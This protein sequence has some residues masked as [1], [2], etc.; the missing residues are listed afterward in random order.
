MHV[1][2]ERR[3]VI[4]TDNRI[5][6]D[7]TEI[8]NIGIIRIDREKLFEEFYRGEIKN[9][10]KDIGRHEYVLENGNVVP[11]IKIIDELLFKELTIKIIYIPDKK[12]HC[13]YKQI[14]TS[15]SVGAGNIL[16]DNRNNMSIK[17]YKE[18]VMNVL[19]WYL[20]ER[21]GI[22]ADFT[23]VKI[24]SMEIN[25][26]IPIQGKF[27][28]YSRIINL[29]IHNLPLRGNI[30]EDKKSRELAKTYSKRNNLEELVMYDKKQQVESK[31][32]TP[33][34]YE[35][36]KRKRELKKQ[37]LTNC[38]HKMKETNEKLEA[39]WEEHIRIE[40][41][42]YNKGKNKKIHS[43]QQKIEKFFGI[44]EATLD[45]ITDE[46]VERKFRQY[47]KEKILLPFCVWYCQRKKEIRKMVIEDKKNYGQS[48]QLY[49]YPKL[50]KIEATT[51]VLYVID[52]IQL[53]DC[54]NFDSPKHGIRLKH[55]VSAIMRG[56]MRKEAK[57]E[58]WDALSKMDSMKIIE[59]LEKLGV[60]YKS[61]FEKNEMNILPRQV[62]KL[63]KGINL[64]IMQ[65]NSD[66]EGEKEKRN[67]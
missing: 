42:L 60:D 65:K 56:I 49:F 26:N 15:M 39:S 63:E 64:V 9:N 2:R 35:K 17:Q 40:L 28:D 25:V 43:S 36:A 51:G 50:Y 52:M 66:F 8:I 31:Y 47:M 58:K 32:N 23:N 21:Y 5:G 37:I 16:P 48:W 20:H 24:Q 41:R 38:P 57:N 27:D 1:T 22:I 44:R 34:R 12:R 6:I 33:A 19:P 11:S 67:I 14:Y 4:M 13:G 3:H 53:R 10:I 30:H 18:Y 7:M 29:M 46:R 45:C 62:R 55:N 54:L 61:E 59:L